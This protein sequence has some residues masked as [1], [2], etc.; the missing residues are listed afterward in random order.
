MRERHWFVG[1]LTS[2]KDEFIDE[3]TAKWV[4][5]KHRHTP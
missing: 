2:L 3:V 1:V 5:G 4:S